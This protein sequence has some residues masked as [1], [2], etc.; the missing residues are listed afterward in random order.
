MISKQDE[1]KIKYIANNS[2]ASKIILFGSSLEPEESNDID[3]AF[4]G[5]RLRII[6]FLWR[7]NL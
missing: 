2:S 3:L 5:G 7:A 1:I 4:E 6:L